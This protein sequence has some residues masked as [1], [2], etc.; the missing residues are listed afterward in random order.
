MSM[1]N[2]ALL[3][4][5]TEKRLKCEHNDKLREMHVLLS[6]LKSGPALSVRVVTGLG[7]LFLPVTAA[8]ATLVRCCSSGATASPPLTVLAL[9]ALRRDLHH[10]AA[11]I[12]T[13]TALNPP[14]T[15][16]NIR[17]VLFV[18]VVHRDGNT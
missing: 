11:A 6:G 18:T 17:C 15:A 3:G 16:S 8:G 2:I 13:A 7:G 12:M 1:K 9:Y 10:S 14:T 5:P 4:T